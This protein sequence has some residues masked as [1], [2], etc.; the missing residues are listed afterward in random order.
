MNFS[1]LKLS[2]V[3]RYNN[4][5]LFQ[6]KKVH[7]LQ[8][9]YRIS[10]K[11]PMKLYDLLIWTNFH[12]YFQFRQFMILDLNLKKVKIIDQYKQFQTTKDLSP[13]MPSNWPSLHANLMNTSSNEAWKIEKSSMLCCDF[14]CCKASKTTLIPPRSRKS[15]AV[16]L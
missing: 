2:I 9:Y 11:N 5:N 16:K 4:K 13:A 12:I 1:Y 7:I 3:N 14:N 10:A 15:S 8:F 6:I